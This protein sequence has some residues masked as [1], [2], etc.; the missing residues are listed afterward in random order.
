MLR[1]FYKEPKDS[2]YNGC[3]MDI[4]PT[5]YSEIPELRDMLSHKFMVANPAIV[6][7]QRMKHLYKGRDEVSLA[8]EAE[9]V[10]LIS[11]LWGNKRE[12]NIVVL[13]LRALQEIVNI[14]LKNNI[15]NSTEDHEHDD[16]EPSFE[17]V[18]VD[19][20]NEIFKSGNSKKEE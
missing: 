16:E 18:D 8:Y 7:S 9:M 2:M 4:Q 20:L 14:S 1:L 11:D 19:E 15:Y 12:E 13:F 5:N 10:N 17:D 3:R 6:F